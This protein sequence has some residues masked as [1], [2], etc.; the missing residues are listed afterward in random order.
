MIKNFKSW[1]AWSKYS[2]LLIFSC[3][4]TWFSESLNTYTAIVTKKK[5][6]SPNIAMIN[7][8]WFLMFQLCDI[9]QKST[10]PIGVPSLGLVLPP[11]P[12]RMLRARNYYIHLHDRCRGLL[13]RTLQPCVA[14]VLTNS[15]IKIFQLSHLQFHNYT[16]IDH[17]F[18]S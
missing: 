15:K 3:D 6:F 14:F 18:K 13:I 8:K 9:M 5:I 1:Q 7:F 10:V 4:F 12:R 11:I 17:N 2:S 16:I